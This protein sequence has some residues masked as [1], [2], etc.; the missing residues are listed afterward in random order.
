MQKIASFVV[1][2]VLLSSC[3]SITGGLQLQ[4][5]PNTTYR[6]DMAITVDNVVYEGTGVLPEK[7]TGSRKIVVEAAEEIDIFTF[8][9]CVKSLMAE[10]SYNVETKV[11][12]LYFWSRKVVDKRKYAFEYQQSSLERSKPACLLV[13]EAY[14]KTKGKHSF[15]LLAEEN[16]RYKLHANLTCNY[17]SGPVGGVSLCHNQEKKW[18]IIGFPEEV[19]FEEDKPECKLSFE[20]RGTVFDFQIMP[21][22]CVYSFLGIKSGLNHQLITLGW[23]GIILRY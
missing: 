9:T 22:I 6:H 5:N 14:N 21:G 10:K 17:D 2:M 8:D 13:M 18:M 4:P 7:P 11:P 12:F 15:G 1:I 23:E 3:G 16:S 19:V 20:K